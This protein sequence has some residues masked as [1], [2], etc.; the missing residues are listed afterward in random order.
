MMNF[1]LDAKID[2]YRSFFFL[3]NYCGDWCVFFFFF[4]KWARW[5]LGSGWKKGWFDGDVDRNALIPHVVNQ[6]N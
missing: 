5:H 1:E 3:W 4:G 2:S 6:D